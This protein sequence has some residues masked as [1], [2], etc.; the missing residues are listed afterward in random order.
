MALA[1]RLAA[2]GL[3]RTGDNPSVGCVLCDRDGNL[4]AAARTADGGRPHAEERAL[5]TAAGR[6]AG[7][8]AYV[9]LEPCRERTT[10]EPS[11]SERLLEAGLARIV[12]AVRDVHPLGAGGSDR[13]EQHGLQVQTGLKSRAAAPLYRAFFERAKSA[14]KPTIHECD[15]SRVPL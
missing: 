4:V 13:L 14:G 6:A 15:P 12:V 11:C 5:E 1:V 2:G 8:T 9:T 10:G 3:G 7:G